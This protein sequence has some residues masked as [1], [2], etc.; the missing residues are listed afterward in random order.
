[1]ITLLHC[2]GANVRECIKKLTDLAQRKFP[3]RG[4]AINSKIKV[5]MGAFLTISIMA[6]FDLAE[7]YKPGIIVEYAVSGNKERAIEELQEKLNA[8]ITPDMEIADLE[9]ETYTTPVTR[10]TYAV[11]VVL[12]NRPI[13]SGL[14]EMKLQ[15]RRKVLAKLLE[16]V[17]FNPK[18]LNI[19]ELARMFGVSRDTIYNDIQQI[20]KNQEG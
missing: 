16:L 17:N 20:L 10:R 19:S 6:T 9:I 15:N 3:P 8:K 1:M 2:E 11:A 12:Y 13:R 18:A 7:P 14:E 4:K 5:T